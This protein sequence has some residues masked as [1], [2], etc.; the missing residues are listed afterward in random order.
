MGRECLNCRFYTPDPHEGWKP[1]GYEQ[2]FRLWAL[3][4]W[5]RKGGR[6]LNT[7]GN[8]W[9]GVCSFEPLPHHVGLL[10]LCG[11]WEAHD[12]MLLDFEGWQ[13]YRLCE[14]ECDRLRAEL[15]AERKRSRERWRALRA[16]GRAK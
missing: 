4:D 3:F 2:R 9:P 11:H 10:Y 13:R 15:K 8:G 12:G 7:A 5:L 14:V 1:H 16:K 6:V